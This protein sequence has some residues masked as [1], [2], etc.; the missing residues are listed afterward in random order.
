MDITLAIA[1]SF[2]LLLIG[3]GQGVYVL[4]PLLGAVAAFGLVARRRGHSWRSLLGLGLGGI[5]K[6]LSVMMILLLIGV[7][8]ALWMAAGTVPALVYWGL[9]MIQPRYFLVWAFVLT[10][11]VSIL[12]GTSFGSASTVGLA[13]MTMTSGSDINPHLVAGAIISGAYVGDRCSPVSSSA[14][15]VA[16]L[17]GTSLHHNLR[18]MARTALLPVALSVLAYGGISLAMPALTVDHQLQG[19][20]AQTFTLHWSVTLPAV[21]VLGLSVGRVA[22]LYTLLLSIGAA[23]AIALMVQGYGLLELLAFALTGFR[24]PADA[25]LV[26]L[27]GGGGLMAMARVCGVVLVSTALAGIVAG[28][29]VLGHV[30]K[31]LSHPKPQGSSFTAPGRERQFLTT[32]LVGMVTAMFGCT[33]TIAILLTQQLVQPQYYPQNCAQAGSGLD[34]ASDGSASP[35]LAL[36]LEN[37]VVVLSP[38]VPWNIAGLVPATVLMTDA[39]F[40]PFAIYLYLQP[41]AVLVQLWS[42]RYILY[43]T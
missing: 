20:I 34:G 35:M 5:H 10:G 32:G 40:I 42:K 4:Y 11:I 22:V 29:N 13:L 25:P 8:V 2:A 16:S 14:N 24:L 3:V 17:T 23:A 7:L 33:Q 28:T 1:V 6:S 43:K 21:V 19:A 15:L 36:D 39:G 37:T 26:G 9:Q 41:L 12:I 30:D 31:L 18:A 38:L 27:F